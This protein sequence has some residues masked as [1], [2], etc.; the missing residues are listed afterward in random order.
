[1]S[2]R[3]Q[4]NLSRSKKLRDKKVS[5]L[6]DNSQDSTRSEKESSNAR[7]SQKDEGRK[8]ET[9]RTR[10]SRSPRKTRESN[11]NQFVTEKP[12][13]SKILSGR[14]DDIKQ[15]SSAL[16]NEKG[17]DANKSASNDRHA[18]FQ[19]N[20]K[21]AQMIGQLTNMHGDSGNRLQVSKQFKEYIQDPAN[22]ELLRY[23]SSNIFTALEEVLKERGQNEL[24][25]QIISSIGLIG[26][27]LDMDSERFFK[28]VF[29]KVPN[30]S[31][32]H[33]RVLYLRTVLEAV[34]LDGGKQTFYSAMP[35]IM[36]SLQDILE[37][38]DVPDLLLVNMDIICIISA[39]YPD[40]FEEYFK[41][42]VDILV[43]WH[44]DTSQSEALVKSTSE[45]LIRFHAYWVADMG[46]SLTLLSQFMEDMEA[47]SEVLKNAFQSD[48]NEEETSSAFKALPKLSSLVSVFTT[49]VSGIGD[50]FIPGRGCLV[51]ASY[52][53]E[54]VTRIIQCTDITSYGIQFEKLLISANDCLKVMIGYLTSHFAPNCHQVADYVTGQLS[55]EETLSYCHLVSILSLLETMFLKVGLSVPVKVVNTLFH[56]DSALYKLR[57]V[58]SAK[59]YAL[60]L[61]T[62]EA[63]LSTK[64]IPIVQA[65]YKCL[66]DDVAENFHTLKAL[67]AADWDDVTGEEITDAEGEMANSEATKEAE[68]QSKQC[69]N[70]SRAEEIH[71]HIIFDLSVLAEIVTYKSAIVGAWN[72]NPNTFHLLT[73]TISPLNEVVA[74][75]YPLVQFSIIS[76]LYTHSQREVC[77][78]WLTDIVKTLQGISSYQFK[79]F[80]NLSSLF[81]AQINASFSAEK[82]VVFLSAMCLEAFL[83]GETTCEFTLPRVLI[84][85]FFHLNDTRPEIQD[86]FLKIILKFP[87]DVLAGVAA[88]QSLSCIRHAS[89]GHFKEVTCREDIWLAK[90]C[91]MMRTA[92]GTLRSHNFKVIM[93]H[94]LQGLHSKNEATWIQDIYFACQRLGKITPPAMGDMNCMQRLCLLHD[95]S[96]PLNVNCSGELLWFWAT[97]E[98]AQFCLLARLKTPLGKAMET[99]NAIEGVLKDLEQ[100]L[101]GDMSR[102]SASNGEKM[103]G[104]NRASNT[105]HDRKLRQSLLLL[106]FLESLEKQMYNAFEGCAVSLPQP[107]RAVRTFFRTNKTT[108]QEWLMRIR[109]PACHVAAMVGCP[110]TAIR[111]GFS[112]LKSLKDSGCVHGAEFERAVVVVASCLCQ[113]QSWESVS[114]LLEW[115]KN[116]AGRNF[117]WLQGFVSKSKGCLENASEQL[118]SGLEKYLSP[119]RQLLEHVEDQRQKKK[120]TV[121][122]KEP[123]I[124]SDAQ[125]TNSLSNE[126]LDC[127]MKLG[128][129]SSVQNWCQH[130]YE[131]NQKLHN[132]QG[133]SAKVD[134]NYVKAMA[135]FDDNDFP[136]VREQ[137]EL[138]PGATIS[139]VLQEQFPVLGTVHEEKDHSVASK[140]EN[141][142]KSVLRLGVGSWKARELM[143]QSK[144]YLLQALTLYWS[145]GL[146]TLKGRRSDSLHSTSWETLEELLTRAKDT[147]MTLVRDLFL[148]GVPNESAL[149]TMQLRTLSTIHDTFFALSNDQDN[150]SFTV[151]I[152]NIQRCLDHSKTDAGVLNEALQSAS[153]LQFHHSANKKGWVAQSSNALSE[154]SGISSLQV[155]SAKLARKQGN[156]K[157][158]EALLAKQLL[159][160]EGKGHSDSKLHNIGNA[161]IRLRQL[162]TSAHSGKVSDPLSAVEILR[163]SAKLKRVL[164]QSSDAADTLCSSIIL[165]ERHHLSVQKTTGACRL[166]EVSASS[167]LT[168]SRWLLAEPKLLN[169]LPNEVDDPVLIGAKI[170]E[171]LKIIVKTGGLS[172][173]LLQNVSFSVISLPECDKI[174]GQLLHFSTH[175]CPSL[176]KTCR[177]GKIELLEE[178]KDK[179]TKI[180]PEGTKREDIESV[181]S[182]L[183]KA[184]SSK[185]I[186]PDE[187]ISTTELTENLTEDDEEKTKYQLTMACPNLMQEPSLISSLLSIWRG[188]VDRVFSYYKQASAAYFT[189][190]KLGDAQLDNL[191]EHRS[192]HGHITATLRILRLLVKYSGELKQ[193]LEAQLGQTPTK[194][195]K[196]IIP[197]L[198]ARLNHPEIYVQTS[199]ASLLCRIAK[200]FPHLIVYPTVVGCS[201]VIPAQLSKTSAAGILKGY[202]LMDTSE[203]CDQ[204]Q[205]DAAEGENEEGNS[206]DDMQQEGVNDK[207]F[208]SS[209]H[210][211]LDSL[212]SDNPCLVSEVKTV[213]KEL[214]RITLLW[215]ELWIGSLMQLNHEAQRRIQQLKEEI[216][217]VNE[218]QT[219]S[220]PQKTALIKEKYTALMKPLVFS[221]ERLEKITSQEPETK[222][223]ESFQK[224]FGHTVHK[225]IEKLKM[226]IDPSDPQKNWEPLKQLH[227]ALHARTNRRSMNTLSMEEISPILAKGKFQHMPLP[228]FDFSGNQVLILESFADEVVILPTK[229][230]PKKLA[231][232]G[233]DGHR[234]S[235]K[236]FV[237]RRY[238]VTP[239]GSRSGLIQWV[240]GSTPIFTLYKRWQQRDAA[241]QNIAKVSQAEKTAHIVPTAPLRP[242][243]LFYNKIS[244]LLKEKGIHDSANSRKDWP[245]AILKKVYHELSDETPCDLLAKEL[246]CSSTTAADWWKATKKYCRSVAVMSMIGYVIG[247]GDRHLDNI[248]V[249]FSTGEVVHIDYNVCFEKGKALRVSEKVPFRMTRNIEAAL[250]ISGVEGLFRISCERVMQILRQGRETLLT[251]LE[252]FVYDPLVDWTTANDAAFAGAFFGGRAAGVDASKYSKKE[253]E[254]SITQTLLATRT[255]EMR[256]SLTSNRDDLLAV[257]QKLEGALSVYCGTL[258]Q[259]RNIQKDRLD[260]QHQYNVL[261]AAIGRAD[262]PLHS[263]QARYDRQEKLVNNL[264]DNKLK[265][266]NKTEE[267]KQFI[268][269]DK[270]GFDKV[271]DNTIHDIYSEIRKPVDIGKPFYEPVVSFLRSAGQA[272]VIAQCDQM[273]TELA[274]FLSQRRSSLRL[275]LDSLFT[276]TTIVVQFPSDYASQTWCAKWIPWLERIISHSTAET[277]NT[278]LK[279]HDMS[280]QRRLRSNKESEEAVTS[281]ESNLHQYYVDQNSKLVKISERR[282]Q[283]P[284]ETSSLSGPVTETWNAMRKFVGDAGV[285]GATSLACVTITALT[286]L[287]ERFMAMENAATVAGDKLMHLTSRDGDWFL[288][289]LCTMCGNIVQLLSVL[290][291][292]PLRPKNFQK[293]ETLEQIN[294][295]MQVLFAS[296]K[297]YG[298]FQEMMSNFRTIILPEALRSIQNGDESYVAVTGE[299]SDCLPKASMSLSNIV[300]NLQ[301]SPVLNKYHLFYYVYIGIRRRKLFSDWLALGACGDE[302]IYEATDDN[303]EVYSVIESMK[304]DLGKIIEPL[305]ETENGKTENVGDTKMSPGQMLLAG[306]SGLFTKIESELG[307]LYDSF[308]KFQPS[309][310]FENLDLHQDQKL[311]KTSKNMANLPFGHCLGYLFARRIQVIDNFFKACTKQAAATRGITANL[312][313]VAN[314]VEYNKDGNT[315]DPSKTDSESIT[316]FNEELL[317]FHVKQFVAECVQ[318]FIVGMPSYSLS[319][320]IMYFVSLLNPNVSKDLKDKKCNTSI[321]DLCKKAVEH[322]LKNS[323]FNHHHL[324]KATSLIHAHDVAWRK[325]D[326]A[327]RLESAAVVQKDIVQ[328]A[329]LQLARFQWLYEQILCSPGKKHIIPMAS[330]SR[331]SVLS[332]IKKRLQAISQIESSFPNILE[333]YSQLQSSIEQRLKWAAGANPALN[334]VQHKFEETV[335]VR[336]LLLASEKKLSPEVIELANAVLR[337]ETFRIFTKDATAFDASV[338]SLVQKCKECC[339]A[340]EANTGELGD[341]EQ[342]MM[343]L[344]IPIPPKEPINVEWMK[345]RLDT[346]DKKLK[347]LRA[348][349]RNLKSTSNSHKETVK[350]HVQS[351]KNLLTGHSSLVGDVKSLLKALAKDEEAP[352]CIVVR[353]F[354]A[355]HN[356][357]SEDASSILRKVLQL[358]SATKPESE[359]KDTNQYSCEGSSDVIDK[360]RE[361]IVITN[362]LHDQLLAFASNVLVDDNEDEE[363]PQTFASALRNQSPPKVPDSTSNLTPKP[364]AQEPDGAS[365]NSVLSPNMQHKIVARGGTT[366]PKQAIGLTKDPKSGKAT[367]EKNMY[368]V[369]VWRRIKAKLEGKDLDLNH[370]MTIPEQVDFVIKEAVDVDNLCQLYEGWTPWV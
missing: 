249:D 230:K 38:A 165:A 15:R 20:S 343:N 355:T 115:C 306:F 71:D 357:F 68:I 241:T 154:V 226:P 358:C 349:E 96:L 203:Y 213:V 86:M 340:L 368:A 103:A 48:N 313:N 131:M 141:D 116:V 148:C 6:R 46:F 123:V 190:L 113:A 79:T 274:A 152:S 88:S 245:L 124:H 107:M 233:S 356:K 168:L 211:I 139:N 61:R 224:S 14:K 156:V 324:N 202:K 218:N 108:C 361:L 304:D 333:R 364:Q 303:Q 25:D 228:G 161:Q 100:S 369:N 328:R 309:D 318:K 276:Y 80:E 176:D 289:E 41:D 9:S 40:I 30:A 109:E 352:E 126:V 185:L 3:G 23:N 90:K 117:F 151:K 201:D 217:R 57:S 138:I 75:R 282:G 33:L 77:T 269:E 56:A 120:L 345:N 330:P 72:V 36:A 326:L 250:G 63:L 229:T 286:T 67:T 175:R 160:S 232:I 191:K 125:V 4:P 94:I 11:K 336:E 220:A 129:W 194:P 95:S 283:E 323:S 49:V 155:Y 247:L 27:L 205:D 62:F 279:E 112:W 89:E 65:A 319:Q 181:M 278:V 314:G 236:R 183:S 267:C 21:L 24:K 238:S 327:R 235:I 216:H 344:Q 53:N 207:I 31:S 188:I 273:E 51:N 275:C 348:K 28:W 290:K 186:S 37:N 118:K 85:N 339:E 295:C 83:S 142:S 42:I 127:Y 270:A 255:A 102:L 121:L 81:D 111:Y 259:Q 271:R 281:L 35:R 39:D 197:Q 222:H 253:M 146:N 312:S 256:V 254:R 329:Q 195:W 221:L 140:K 84:E 106:Q 266:Q 316:V 189:Y 166:S 209:L 362:W 44:I 302:F 350:S 299:F 149:I 34:R 317:A 91:H 227:A 248:L 234:S 66:A 178:E 277:C 101:Q 136:G 198:F 97:W 240:D 308:K 320:L 150:E 122:T 158:A 163:E 16:T 251:L 366:S 50:L 223:E 5:S 105:T 268:G 104:S 32:D 315:G 159:L 180:L 310:S 341:V 321:D 187:D 370:R 29:S 300:E 365:T 2:G 325:H 225:V 10:T 87:V 192:E 363:G 98:A 353:N 305:V 82:S 246:W 367:Q 296:V 311:P 157:L 294:N 59:V 239:L 179:I 135:K 284:K 145:S 244:P 297:V 26:L 164:G 354:I 338:V 359:S 19:D 360:I 196:G 219:L 347:T 7:T 242:S 260:I 291:N 43:G 169:S 307:S 144:L 301:G 351:V 130:L 292:N 172:V 114:G 206:Q 55:S 134:L 128:D 237:A 22:I 132:V 293:Q 12:S 252:A 204:P 52:V 332:E 262:H 184:H 285:A 342:L 208:Q 280:I 337:L 258:N 99:F 93:G 171:I 288:D 110:A 265:I 153:Y 74:V 287:N 47:Y 17:R 257:L 54:T 322:C 173:K 177:N 346:A 243:E 58:R 70:G 212:S 182:I 167:L 162:S 64:N 334:L 147:L 272:N 1:M 73:N 214:R 331:S 298:S 143:M 215:D 92:T 45:C 193:E 18:L 60:L 174:C 76:T 133:L 210:T 137:L 8:K 78:L 263:L 170:K 119:D 199:V 231:M 335:G 13:N 200:D 69:E 261:M 264:K